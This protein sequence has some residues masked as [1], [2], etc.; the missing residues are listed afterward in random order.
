M[1]VPTTISALNFSGV[2]TQN[3]SLSDASSLTA[4]TK[5]QGVSEEH[6]KVFAKASITLT[7]K[8][9]TA[10]GVETIEE[11]YKSD[12]SDVDDRLEL[13]ELGAPERTAESKIIGETAVSAARVLLKDVEEASLIGGW[14]KV[15]EEHGLVLVTLRGASGNDWTSKMAQGFQEVGGERRF[16]R[17]IAFTSGVGEKHTACLV[18]DY[19]G[20]AN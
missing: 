1:S 2:Y 14:D 4:M 15:T 5:A 8:H 7:I 20:P 11:E 16:V 19:Q 17:R 3:N 13:L 10:N 18:F 9:T 12:V 6:L